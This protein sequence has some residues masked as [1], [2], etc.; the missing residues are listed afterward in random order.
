MLNYLSLEQDVEGERLRSEIVENECGPCDA[1]THA[2][3]GRR[4][5]GVG[6]CGR[7]FDND[8]DPTKKDEYMDLLKSVKQ[9][10]PYFTYWLLYSF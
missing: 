3:S 4:I 6:F 8:F 10:R 2:F 9:H 1:F 7:L 5:L